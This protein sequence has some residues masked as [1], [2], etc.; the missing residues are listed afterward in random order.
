M[1]LNVNIPI[2][3]SSIHIVQFGHLHIVHILNILSSK[4][5]LDYLLVIVSRKLFLHRVNFRSFLVGLF[6]DHSL[7]LDQLNYF[8]VTRYIGSLIRIISGSLRTSRP[9]ARVSATL[10]CASDRHY[11]ILA[12]TLRPVPMRS[13]PFGTKLEPSGF[14]CG[15][16]AH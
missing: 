4:Y 9:Q 2:I 8:G 7:F 11:K 14:K 16:S 5:Y 12:F 13:A 1:H 6:L 3:V 15:P 10:R